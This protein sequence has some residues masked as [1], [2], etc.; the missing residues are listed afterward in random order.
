MS[1]DGYSGRERAV[2]PEVRL[3]LPEAVD[4]R[5]PVDRERDR[6]AH[7]LVRERLL[8]RA[9]VELSVR[10]GLD[11]DHLRVRVVQQRLAARDGEVLD[12]VDLVPLKR[13][14]HRRFL[15]VELDVDPVD[16]RLLAPV[17]LVLDDREADLGREAL[18]LE[19]AGALERLAPVGGVEVRRNDD[20]VV[21]GGA[22]ER[23]EVAVRRVEVED[24][25]GVVGRLGVAGRED[26]AERGLGV[27]RASVGVD[28]LVEGGDDVVRSQRR[29]VVERDALADLERP[30]RPVRVRL[31]ALGDARLELEFVV[32]EGEELAGGAEDAGAALVLDEQRVGLG[33]RL[34]QRDPD[35]AAGLEVAGCG[36]GPPGRRG[37][38]VAAG[39]V[40][41]ASA[42]GREEGEHRNRHADDGAAADELA[43]A[44]LSPCVLVDEVVLELAA[45]V[46]DVVDSALLLVHESASPSV[47]AQRSLIADPGGTVNALPPNGSDAAARAKLGGER[48]LPCRRKTGTPMT[49]SSPAAQTSISTPSSGW[50]GRAKA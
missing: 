24:D 16:D 33:R 7:A 36:L 1:V 18:E 39:L 5:L 37:L 9:H 34:D 21:V 35:R 48:S 17:G 20:R 10:S 47:G 13:E 11:G 4:E 19:R 45:L 27:R 2:V 23:G 43:P 12:E 25:R 31:P 42:R 44:D 38:G 29:A 3:A 40:V 46:A 22:D 15:V 26:P 50:P 8:V 32:G 6:L 28:Q 41:V 30:D 14:D 49:V